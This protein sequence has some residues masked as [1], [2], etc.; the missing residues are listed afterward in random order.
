MS[1]IDDINSFASDKQ[2]YYPSA[3]N[4]LEE[5]EVKPVGGSN[6]VV[7]SNGLSGVNGTD[8]QQDGAGRTMSY[9]E[10]LQ[11]LSPYKPKTEEELEK[12]RKKQKR[13]MVFAAIGDGLNAFNQAYANAA[14]VKPM[15]PA[16]SLTGKLRERYEQL[17]KERE[18]NQAQY[19]NAYMRAKQADDALAQQKV[20]NALNER[21]QDRL[22]RETSI[23]EEKARAYQLYQKAV[24]EKNEEQAAYWRAKWEAL[25][26]GATQEQALKA[27]KTAQAN[28]S[29]RLSNVRAD[30]GGFASTANGGVG[31]Y[32]VTETRT[33]SKGRVT[34]V[35]KKRV[36]TGGTATSSSA[37]SGTG[38]GNPMQGRSKQGGNGKKNPM[39]KRR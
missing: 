7:G 30:A 11:Q 34:T 14:G 21:R 28:A 2:N 1:T 17:R 26:A 16:V 36:P 23:K 15:A 27:A 13:E 22:E 10:L 31:G 6:G 8:E 25:E 9:V 35:E 12:E 33:D 5:V 37:T 24:T 38:K 19:A 32:E 20:T 18:A 3:V 39:E 4:Q 29:A